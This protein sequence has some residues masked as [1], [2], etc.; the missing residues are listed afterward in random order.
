M[1]IFSV[2]FFA[3]LLLT[4]CGNP[5]SPEGV[6]DKL[7]SFHELS[8]EK[9]QDRCI[10]PFTKY[11]VKAPVAWEALAEVFGEAKTKKQM[12]AIFASAMS[13]GDPLG[14]KECDRYMFR[15]VACF[16]LMTGD[17]EAAAVM[18]KALKTSMRSWRELAATE[19]GKAGLTET[20]KTA[21]TTLLLTCSW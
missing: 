3:G 21:E 12:D 2:F 7:S 9:L 10:G 1:R 15:S 8:P 19:A 17:K 6:C 5:G 20:C 18:S 14:I 11:Q 16:K 13:S 4:A